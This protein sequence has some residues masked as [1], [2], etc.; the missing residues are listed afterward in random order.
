M[1]VQTKK[2]LKQQKQKKRK[3]RGGAWDQEEYNKLPSEKR[4]LYYIEEIKL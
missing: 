2:V 3:T 1:K 4:Q